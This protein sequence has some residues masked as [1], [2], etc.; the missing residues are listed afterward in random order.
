M[1]NYLKYEVPI[2]LEANVKELLRNE[3][4][5]QDILLTKAHFHVEELQLQGDIVLFFGVGSI[6]AMLAAI[7]CI[8]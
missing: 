6:E 3:E 4:N 1:A 8:A 7:E 2:F 5:D